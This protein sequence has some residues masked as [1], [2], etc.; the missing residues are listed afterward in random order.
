MPF[1]ACSGM[2]STMRE[3]RSEIAIAAPAERVWEV[4]TDFEVYPEWNP[5]MRSVLGSCETGSRLTVRIEPPGARAMTFKPT[6]LTA[7]P[8]RELRWL[9]RLLVPGLFDGEHRL[10]IEPLNGGGTRFV[11]SERFSGLLVGLFAKTLA[12]TQR[13]FEQMN[14]ALKTRAEGG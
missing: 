8:E 6:I 5:F 3:L 10:T 7:E 4:L 9:G 14:V 13:G 11:Q 1:A 2:V 12:A